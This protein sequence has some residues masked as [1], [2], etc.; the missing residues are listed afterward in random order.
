MEMVSGTRSG[1]S[2]GGYELTLINVLT[3]FNVKLGGVRVEGLIS[4]TVV[5]E[6]VVTVRSVVLS[7]KYFSCL[8]GV[9]VR[10]A[11]C[12]NIDSV[13]EF[14]IVAK[15]RDGSVSVFI[16]NIIPGI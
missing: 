3:C 5:Y 8:G 13:M 12:G 11:V 10:S 2:D 1:S 9:Y 6:N 16:G 14:V 7:D 4:V 15:L